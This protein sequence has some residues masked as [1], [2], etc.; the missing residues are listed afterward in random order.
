MT[1]E[2]L[3][4]AA[5]GW[6]RHFQ[7]QTDPA[8]T[9]LVP[10]RA[11]AV[12]RSEIEAAGADFSGRIPTL[13]PDDDEGQV[14]VGDWLLVDR[15]TRM[16][17]RLLERKSLFKRK[18]AGT[19]ERVQPIAANVDTLFV[20]TSCNR[21]FN[22]ARLERYLALAREADA[23]PLVIVTKAD[24][25]DEPESYAAAARK[26]MPG[27]MVECL[28]ARDE[29]A[30]AALAPWCG[31]GE[32]VA[33][34]G[35][36]GVGK[37]TL[38]NTLA[39]TDIATAGIREDDARG[40]HTTTAR[41]MHRLISGGW[42]IDTPGMRELQLADA[43]EGI[44]AV[45]ADIVAIAEGCRFADC[46]HESEPGCAVRAA[47]E[48]GTLDPERLARYRKLAREDKRNSE[49]IWQRRSRERGFGKM[50]KGIMKEK[51][52]RFEDG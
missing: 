8:D 35:S 34:A 45:F 4:L 49:A 28:D 52:G 12:H 5:L 39:G 19:T 11:M 31:P 23:T 40:R 22:V 15:A 17:K 27:L 30:V 21:D 29:T 44:D 6:S 51:R 26:L 18:A 48:E 50:V 43:A 25:A 42:L 24:L 10:M 13:R 14:A 9:G 33:L 16:P 32:T 1:T 37:S 36:S 47:I 7:M 20:V 2:T 38:V 46:G 41:A 3:S